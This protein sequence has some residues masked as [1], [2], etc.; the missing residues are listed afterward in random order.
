MTPSNQRAR[1]QP[2]GGGAPTPA[3]GAARPTRSRPAPR[4]APP[5]AHPWAQPP[6]RALWMAG[7][8]LLPL[9]AFLGITFCFAGLQK[10]ANPAFFEASNPIS[11]QAQLHGALRRSPVHALLSPLVHVAVPLGVLIALAE[12]AIGAGTLLGLW[13]RVAAVGGAVLSF[14]LFLTVSFHSSPYYTGADIVFLFAWLPLVLTGS[15]GVL[16]LDAYLAE[17]TRRAAGAEPSAVVPIPFAVVRRVCG[18]F[19]AG[20]CTMRHGAPCEPAPCPFLAARPPRPPRLAER[21]LDRRTFTTK[22][23]AA[24]AAGLA[25]LVT[26]GAAAAAGRLAGGS[27]TAPSTPGLSPRRTG[28]P[29]PTTP[30]SRPPGGGSGPPAG[31]KPPGTALGPATAVPVGGA[32]SFNDPATGDPSLVVQPQSGTFL[33]FD[34]VCPHAGCTVEW[35][36][37][38]KFFVCPCHGS[39]FNGRTGAVETGPAATG[40]APIAIAEG[41]DGQLYAK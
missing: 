31:A 20:R 34:A 41:P 21:E 24:A 26:G 33:A 22:G 1:R 25:A 28:S 27:S 6:P 14:F 29:S 35:D 5:P 2:G 8:A 3:R 7:W 37:A 15:G 19:D 9:R 30:T 39:E 16:S 40:L 23:V 32:A 36:P 10:L 4:P 11:I 12:L 18:A 17:R 13:A 38:A